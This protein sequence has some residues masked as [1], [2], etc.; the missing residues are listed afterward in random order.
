M[1]DKLRQ[2][3]E[4]HLRYN[5]NNCKKKGVFDILNDISKNVT[6]VQFMDTPTKFE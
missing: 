6:L 4:K 3:G 5:L 1:K 2:I